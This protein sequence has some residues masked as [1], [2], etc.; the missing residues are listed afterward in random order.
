MNEKAPNTIAGS[1]LNFAVMQLSHVTA[2]A[3]PRGHQ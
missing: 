2:G 1:G 3:W